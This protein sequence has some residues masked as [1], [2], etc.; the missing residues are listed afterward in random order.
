MEVAEQ[1]VVMNHGHIEQVGAPREVYEEPANEF[2]MSFVGPVNQLSGHSCART[3]STCSPSPTDQASEAMVERI[4]H[5][6]FEVRVELTLH[7]GQRVSVQMTQPEAEELELDRGSDRVGAA[8]PQAHV[9]DG[10]SARDPGVRVLRKL[11]DRGRQRAG[12][13]CRPASRA[14]GPRACSCAARSRRAQR[15][16]RPGVADVLGRL[17]AE[18]ASGPSTMRMTSATVISSAG[19]PASSRRRRPRWLRTSPWR[20]SSARMFSRNLSGMSWA[21]AMRSPLTGPSA[22]RELDRRPHGIV[23]LR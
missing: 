10:P 5:L 8:Q 11:L 14:P 4:I 21:S 16:R 23:R 2:V 17:A 15:L 6:G 3:T 1:I 9:R 12:R 7:D 22:E 19:W 18:L 20:R 13:R